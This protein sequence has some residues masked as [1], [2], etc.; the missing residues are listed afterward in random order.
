MR[1]YARKYHVGDVVCG[2]RILKVHGRGSRSRGV[3]ERPCGHRI[4][5]SLYATNLER[6]AARRC[7]LCEGRGNPAKQWDLD[8]RKVTVP[9]AVAEF[10]INA[11]TARRRL[12]SGLPLDVLFHVPNLI[13]AAGETLTE[14]E[15][16][17]RLD[18]NRS[19]IAMRIASGWDPARAVTTPVRSW[20]HRQRSA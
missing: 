16:A 12:T 17:R 9:Q 11:Q 1:V 19:T 3:V 18:C 5:A 2:L 10:G 4:V 7:T 20:G 14:A 6:V 15:W 13:T 8:G